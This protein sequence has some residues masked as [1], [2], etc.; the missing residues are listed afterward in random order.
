M[1]LKFALLWVQLRHAYS[2]PPGILEVGFEIELLGL[3]ADSER[4]ILLRRQPQNLTARLQSLFR[5]DGS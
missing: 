2:L 5:G 3:V 1:A 4:I